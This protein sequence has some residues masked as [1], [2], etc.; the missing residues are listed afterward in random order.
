MSVYVTGDCHSKF[1]K[2]STSIFT[3]QKTLT[4]K[5]CVIILGDFGGIWNWKG[6]DKHEKYWLDWLQDKPFTTLF[7]CGNHENFERLYQYPQKDWHGGMVHEVRPNVLHLMRGYVFDIDGWTFFA[8]GGA[9]SHDITGGILEPDDPQLKQKIRRL[10]KNWEC[11]R[12]NH[13]TWWKE[14]MPNEQEMQS[15][16]KH[17]AEFDNQV[18][19]ILTHDCPTSTQRQIDTALY[20]PNKLNDYLETLKQTVQ[21]EHWYFGHYHIDMHFGKESA[22]YDKII[23]IL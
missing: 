16:L 15:G 10:D 20:S 14:E 13:R 3:K 21:Y 12:I 7:V 8:F 4:K 23:Q 1:H 9:A 6:E 11:Y 5:D 2:L 18:D 22:V 19:F 17:L